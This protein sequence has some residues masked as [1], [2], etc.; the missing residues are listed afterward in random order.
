MTFTISFNDPVG[1]DV[2]KVG[3]KG[4]NLGHLT[5]AGFQVPAGFT[6]STEAY[7]DFVESAGLRPKLAEILGRIDFADADALEAGSRDIRALI[8]GTPVSPALEVEVIAAYAGLGDDVRVAVRSSGTAE[9]MAGSSF[10]GLHDTYLDI[11]GAEA[12]LDAVRRCWGSMWSAR[13]VSYRQSQGFG[14]DNVSMAVVVQEMVASQVSGVMFTANPLDARTDEIVVNASLGLGEAIVSGTV[15]PDEHV[16]DLNTLEVKRQNL[17]SKEL[18]IDRA[19][20][21]VGT[22]ERETTPTEREAFCLTAAQLADLAGLGRQIMEHYEGFPQDIEWAYANGRFYVLQSRPVTGV[23][24][25]WEEALEEATHDF[26]EDENTLWTQRWAEMVWTGGITP[27]FYSVRGRHYNRGIDYMADLAGL[28]ELTGKRYYK[29]YKGTIY[30]NTDFHRAFTEAMPRFAR[31]SMLEALPKSWVAPTMERPLDILKY[32]RF[33]AGVNG[34][35]RSGF[36]TWIDSTNRF[37]ER[38]EEAN[39]ISAAQLRNLTD[40][41]L[42]KYA[43]GKSEMQRL[44]SDPIWIGVNIA[45]PHVI[46][47]LEWL[48]GSFYTGD[49]KQMLQDLMSGLPEQTQQSIESHE[50][51]H[52]SQMIRHAP[53]LLALFQAHE[54]AAFFEHASECPAGVAFL[55]RYRQFIVDHGH[56]GQADRD[57]CYVRREEDPAIDYEAL[58]G[59]L[60]NEDPTPPAEVE[61]RVIKR[62]E[63]ATADLLASFADKPFGGLLRQAAIYLQKQILDT[64]LV[65]DNWRHFADRITNAKRK[66]YLEMGMRCVER[67]RL[68]NAD[69]VFFLSYAEV[70]DVMAGV[71]SIKLAKAKIA[72]R[73]RAFDAVNRHEVTFPMHLRNGKPV[74]IDEPQDANSGTLQ[75]MGMSSGTVKGK[76]RIVPDIKQ[77]GRVEKGDILICNATDPGWASVFTLIDGLVIQTGG[78]LAHGACL[79]REY[80][81]PAL[82]IRNAMQ[83]VRD[84]AEVE[85]RGDTGELVLLD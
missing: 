50:L 56:R 49:N 1:R 52:L 21:A 59:L 16:I 19:A 13:A 77:I 15:V 67:G 23:E 4:A 36:R 55:E 80:G 8:E 81:I 33:F 7:Q 2:A 79:S 58:R 12:V 71:G 65:R 11:I 72:A 83:L 25:L 26:P 76:A 69:D 42:K 82:Q 64:L 41:A 63:A 32:I 38:I 75:G 73:R 18:R 70:Y 51:F 46:G 62:R 54:G 27:L 34:S 3:G 48:V 14:E 40:E 61:A 60:K 53:D 28:K 43:Y 5:E 10:A 24:F 47:A 30:Y 44:F 84:G 78:M 31:T 37:R 35:H 66:A 20:G 17:G 29:Y 6:V 74:N 9:D 85:V 22:T 68:D 39:G 45:M 57:A